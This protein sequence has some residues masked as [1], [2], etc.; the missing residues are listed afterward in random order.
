MT[1]RSVR[2][3]HTGVGALAAITNPVLDD[4][5]VIGQSWWRAWL[6]QRGRDD[7]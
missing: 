7:G 2:G 1:R 6:R 5:S 3:D 4:L